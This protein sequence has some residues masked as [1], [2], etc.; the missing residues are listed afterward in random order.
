[1]FASVRTVAVPDAVRYRGLWL[2]CIAAIGSAAHWWTASTSTSRSRRS[3]SRSGATRRPIRPPTCA[4]GS[5]RPALS[6]RPVDK[7]IRAFRRALS[8]RAHDRILKVARTIADL[9]RSAGVSPSAG[10]R[11]VE[12]GTSYSLTAISCACRNIDRP[13]WSTLDRQASSAGQNASFKASFAGFVNS[14][15]SRP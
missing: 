1:M 9:D 13:R 3:L 12:N 10:Y 2:T 11:R 7:T 4:H 14:F 8:A 15:E 6:S 5:S